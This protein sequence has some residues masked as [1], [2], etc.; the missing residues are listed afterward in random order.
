MAMREQ[1][2]RH[3]APH[4]IGANAL[5]IALASVDSHRARFDKDVAG[6]DVG[7][8]FVEMRPLRRS[9]ERRSTGARRGIPT[10][11]RRFCRRRFASDDFVDGEKQG[12]S[13]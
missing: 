8:R 10:L 3:A 12:E 4:A 13:P 9:A 11:Q 2:E 7:D 6:S 1:D 5:K